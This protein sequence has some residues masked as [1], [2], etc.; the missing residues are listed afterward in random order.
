MADHTGVTD[1][2]E[3]LRRQQLNSSKDE[4]LISAADEIDRLRR[5]LKIARTQVHFYRNLTRLNPLRPKHE[6]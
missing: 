3:Q 6:R 2:T 4:L 5:E 1:I